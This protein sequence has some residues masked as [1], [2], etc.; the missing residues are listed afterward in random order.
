MIVFTDG[1]STSC[2]SVAVSPS[3]RPLATTLRAPNCTDNDSKPRPHAIAPIDR[4]TRNAVSPALNI[5]PAN[6]SNSCRRLVVTAGAALACPPRSGDVITKAST[7]IIL[8]LLRGPIIPAVCSRN[9]QDDAT[10]YLAGAH[11]I[12]DVIDIFHPRTGVIAFDEPTRS[13]R[14]RVLQV[15][16]RADD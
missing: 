16:A 2:T 8:F 7:F 5:K 4:R 10:V 9:F 1:T 11:F 14:Q 13:Q 3:R 12:K 6:R 15:F